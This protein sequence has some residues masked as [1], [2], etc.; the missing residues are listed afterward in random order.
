MSRYKDFGSG[1]SKDS[2]EPIVFKIHGEEFTCVPEVQGKVLLKI[3]AEAGDEDPSKAANAINTFFNFV[4][5]DESAER[6]NALTEDKHRVVTVETLTDIIG[7][8]MEQ[9]T[10]RPEAQPEV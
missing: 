10:D 6:F 1:S 2:K 4:L 5:E 7:W 3:V 9:Y 8:L